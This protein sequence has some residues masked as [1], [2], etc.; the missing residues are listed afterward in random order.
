MRTLFTVHAGEYLTASHIEQKLK[1]PVWIPS[2]DKGIDLLVTN[3]A[4]RRAISLQVKYGK[5]F[6]PGKRPVIRE[7]FRCISWFTLDTAKV[8]ASPAE[9]WVFVLHSFKHRE[10]DF[11]VVRRGELRQRL[12]ALHGWHGK[13]QSVL[14]TTET[15]GCW[16]G[17][18]REGALTRQLA[19][20]NDAEPRRDFTKYLNDWHAVTKHLKG[21]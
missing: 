14:C 8:D 15:G 18:G 13:I 21:A 4:N 3:R 12:R 5:D 6:L 9:L 16:E 19:A 7:A 20:G 17:R 1:L 10:P 11:V 2:K